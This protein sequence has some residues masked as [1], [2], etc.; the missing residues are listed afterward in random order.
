[1]PSL[2]ISTNVGPKDLDAFVKTVS[3]K[4]SEAIGKPE[5]LCLIT[6]N[7]VQ[8]FS[9]AGST[10]P[11]FIAHVTSIGNI[12]N[13]RNANLSASISQFFQE[14]LSIPNNRGY[15]FFHDARGDDT[16]FHGTTYTNLVAARK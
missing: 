14:E 11:G 16:G 6:F 10:D 1:M 4:F 15:F 2:E 13:E 9:F 7:Q 3:K 5:S 8:H 12:D